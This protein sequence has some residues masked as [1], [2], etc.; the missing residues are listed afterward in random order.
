MKT[1]AFSMRISIIIPAKD[2]A[3]RLPSFLKTVIHYCRQSTHEY[4]IIV[5]D[6]GSQDETAK[7]ALAFREEFP[8][9]KV[10]S[11]SSNHGKGYAVK[12]G[13]LAAK[14]DVVLFLDADGSTG[15][16]EIGRYLYLFEEGYDIIIGSRVLHDSQSRVKALFYRRWIGGVFNF[17][18]HWLLIK[19]IKDTQCGFKMFRSKIVKSLFEN[20][21]LNGFGFDLELLYI[22]QKKKFHIKEVSV[23]WTH[24]EGSKVHLVK[25]SLRMF[26]NI[27]EIRKWHRT[28]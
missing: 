25:D 18:V 13:F 4:E 11:F 7:L 22:A 17:L 15:P 21:H 27:L 26:L 10:I 9:L 14:G 3:K 20:I 1:S 5:V 6:D 12:Q 2:E 24:V 16:Q 28:S 23:N 19:N 8:A